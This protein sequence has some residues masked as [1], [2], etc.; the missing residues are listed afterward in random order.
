MFVCA[1]IGMNWFLQ[2]R[3]YKCTT[4]NARLLRSR[5]E[6][7]SVFYLQMRDLSEVSMILR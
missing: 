2:M 5:Y 6:W 1:G 3:D 4:T 7:V